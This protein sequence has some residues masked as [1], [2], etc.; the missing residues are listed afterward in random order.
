MINTAKQTVDNLAI[1]LIKTDCMDALE[2]YGKFDLITVAE[3]LHWF[4]ISNFINHVAN[5]LLNKEGRFV[6]IGYYRK[7]IYSVSPD[8]PLKDVYKEYYD[9]IKECS[10]FDQKDL[11]EEY[12]ESKYPFK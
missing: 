11:Y 8:N 3:A 12:P 7:G 6:V 4:P 1:K 5:N 10:K 2:E 9:I